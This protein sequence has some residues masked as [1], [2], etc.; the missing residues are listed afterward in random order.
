[1]NT[2]TAT[3][4]SAIIYG[5]SPVHPLG[6]FRLLLGVVT[7]VWLII[8]MNALRKQV[9]EGSLK[10]TYGLLFSLGVGLV[11]AISFGLVAWLSCEW[12]PGFWQSYL[13]DQIR[14]LEQATGILKANY[15]AG[16]LDKLR[17][18]IQVQSPWTLILRISFFRF[19]W[20]LLAGLWVGMYFRK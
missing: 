11:S 8:G 19:V 14:N 20:H 2:L 1:M 16:T 9:F 15:S 6:Q 17:R 18:E 5:W 12:V 4:L 7:L 13:V 10:V 3:V